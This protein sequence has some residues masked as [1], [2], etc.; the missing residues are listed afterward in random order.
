M[1]RIFIEKNNQG[2]I[3]IKY[4]DTESA[5]KCQDNLNGK[6]FDNHKIF[7]YF[8][9]ENTYQNRVGIW[10]S[11]NPSMNYLFAR[12]CRYITMP[13]NLANL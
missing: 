11:D 12:F 4:S 6:F 5:K 8:V 3:W 2:N 1:E 10:L 9:T 7:C 13:N